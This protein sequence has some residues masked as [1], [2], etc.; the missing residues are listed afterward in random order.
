MGIARLAVGVSVVVA[1]GWWC[2]S[3][4][5]GLPALR[6]E[7]IGVSGT[8]YLSQGEV[9]ALVDGM[10]GRNI[11]FV[12]L[13]AWRQKVLASPWVADATMY[14]A[15]PDTIE[16]RVVERH[17]LAI[18][19]VGGELFL[20]DDSGS[21][22]DEYGPRYAEFDL[23]ILDGL[24]PADGPEA[25]ANESR[26]SLAARLLREMRSKP[27]LAR[28]I[29]QVDVSDPR[30][31]VVIVDQDTARVRLGEGQFVERLQSYLDMAHALRERVPAI[32]Y[33]DLRFGERWVIGAQGSV[34]P[35]GAVAAAVRR[36]GT[37]NQ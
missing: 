18:S 32:D 22:I 9:G 5:Y 11:L 6:I 24:A 30:D 25:A 3:L 27:D 14:R 1:I 12:D 34:V 8:Q 20:I 15:L 2:Q 19:R 21:V 23:P 28:R 7:R 13:E 26:V 31:A 36:P 17:P 29:S 4:L 35:A 37:T 33:V 16:V 10:K